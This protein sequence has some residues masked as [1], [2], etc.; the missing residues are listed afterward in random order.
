MIPRYFTT[1]IIR[2]QSNTDRRRQ[3]LLGMIGADE[4]DS[5]DDGDFDDDYEQH[6]QRETLTA[7]EMI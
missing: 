6:A 2:V 7:R 5:V 4:P 1:P 3:L